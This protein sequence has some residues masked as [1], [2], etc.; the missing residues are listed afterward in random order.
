M[1]SRTTKA[2]LLKAAPLH[3]AVAWQE[4]MGPGL[5][6]PIQDPLW[7]RRRSNPGLQRKTARAMQGPSQLFEQRR[8][9]PSQR[10]RHDAKRRPMATSTALP[11]R[12]AI[13][14]TSS[15]TTTFAGSSSSACER[16]AA[17][18]ARQ[19]L[20]PA[21]GE[22]VPSSPRHHQ[23]HTPQTLGP[24]LRSGASASPCRCRAL[25]A[26]ESPNLPSLLIAKKALFYGC[27]VEAARIVR[28][29]ELSE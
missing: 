7:R 14:R 29:Q 1:A 8:Q 22:T 12:T 6:S 11:A 4:L 17:P 2:A 3:A 16:C 15:T 13:L 19:R 18:P 5:Q 20:S 25:N 28:S 9:W 24:A 26:I 10:R 27:I 23:A 21:R